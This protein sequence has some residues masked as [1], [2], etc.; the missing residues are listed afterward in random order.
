MWVFTDDLELYEDS[1]GYIITSQNTDYYAVT[2]KVQTHSEEEAGDQNFQVIWIKNAVTL[3]GYSFQAK[4]IVYAYGDMNGIFNDDPSEAGVGV[5]TTSGSDPHDYVTIPGAST[6][7][8]TAGYVPS[9]AV[10]PSLAVFRWDEDES[11]YNVTTVNSATTM[12]SSTG[13][14]CA[15]YQTEFFNEL[16][17]TALAPSTQP[18]SYNI[19]R[20]GV[21]VGNIPAS[22]TTY[23]DHNLS[24]G[25]TYS[26][27]VYSVSSS[28]SETSIGTATVTTK[29]N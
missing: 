11:T 1:G 20:D 9:Y 2:W 8:E 7:S 19:Y 18:V 14:N 3:G 5:T 16:D 29:G 10:L 25:T 12:E 13:K 15:L 17:W 27:V 4:D 28:G 21:I 23:R 22:S 6:D 26:Y 24:S